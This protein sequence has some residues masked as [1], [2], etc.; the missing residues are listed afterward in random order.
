MEQD[1]E[2]E[3]TASFSLSFSHMFTLPNGDLAVLASTS[4]STSV[5]ETGSSLSESESESASPTNSDFRWLAL[6]HADGSV[7]TDVSWAGEGRCR[8]VFYCN[9]LASVLFDS[10]LKDIVQIAVVV[11]AGLIP[12][13]FV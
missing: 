1:I 13:L 4:T 9:F 6:S 5:P 8:L 2:H 3:W 7:K 12:G 10:W 11:T